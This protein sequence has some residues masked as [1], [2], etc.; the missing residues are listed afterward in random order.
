MID[1]EQE[2]ENRLRQFQLLNGKGNIK[3]CNH[4]L[5]EIIRLMMGA[6][7]RNTHAIEPSD[8]EVYV[9]AAVPET[10]VPI[11]D[12]IAIDSHMLDH[13]ETN[14]MLQPPVK[15]PAPFGLTKF[16]NPKR[17]RKKQT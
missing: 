2:I 8:P 10:P 4:T 15:R 13:P 7:A 16:G 12:Q 1:F 6:I 3:D 17:I 14:E 5:Y 9:P 11:D